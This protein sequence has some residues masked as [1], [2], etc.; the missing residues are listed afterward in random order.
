MGFRGFQSLQKLEQWPSDLHVLKP[1]RLMPQFTWC[2]MKKSQLWLSLVTLWSVIVVVCCSSVW[3][4]FSSYIHYWISNDVSC[5][6]SSCWWWSWCSTFYDVQVEVQSIAVFFR[7]CTDLYLDWF[8]GLA[9]KACL[10]PL[11]CTTSR[12][13]ASELIL[14]M[15]IWTNL[16]VWFV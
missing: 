2:T 6:A 1:K 16:Y 7:Y 11:P 15:R 14:L 9:S 5:Q 13:I 8:P 4:L 3:R 12:A 10:D